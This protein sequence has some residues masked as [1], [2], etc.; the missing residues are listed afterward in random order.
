MK[1]RTRPVPGFL[2]TGESRGSGPADPARDTGPAFLFVCWRRAGDGRGLQLCRRRARLSPSSGLHPRL[3]PLIPPAPSKCLFLSHPSFTV[4]RSVGNLERMKRV[5]KEP[6][7]PVFL[8]PVVPLRPPPQPRA[9]G[10]ARPPGWSTVA[11]VSPPPQWRWAGSL[12]PAEVGE[13]AR[14]LA[15]WG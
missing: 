13:R 5:L 10:N 9:T 7:V 12:G 8:N 1:L 14:V 6:G 15:L 3:S 2:Q 4:G 11:G